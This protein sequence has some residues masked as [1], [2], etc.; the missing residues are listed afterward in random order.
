MKNDY[1]SKLEAKKTMKRYGLTVLCTLPLLILVGFLLG[2]NIN[3]FVRILIFSVIL[4]AA[5]L[6][7]E[8]IHAKRKLKQ[9]DQPKKQKQHEDVFKK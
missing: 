2:D 8:Y 9:Q 1:Q 3:R 5:V 4:V 6:I 7:E